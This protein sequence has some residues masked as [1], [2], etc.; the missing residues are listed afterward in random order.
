MSRTGERRDA[1]GHGLYCEIDGSPVSLLAEDLTTAGFFV[2][3]T[4][5]KA[6][7]REVEIF[8]RSPVGELHALGQ[9]VQ[10]VD[11]RRAKAEKRRTGYG[12]LFTTLEDDQRAFI[13]LTLDALERKQRAKAQAAAKSVPVPVAATVPPPSP[14]SAHEIKQIAADLR[15]ELTKLQGKTAWT[16]LGLEPDA[17]LASAKES[18]LRTSKRFH[19][20]KFARHNSAE[21]TKLATE[22]F[23]AYKRSYSVLTKLAPRGSTPTQ[24]VSRHQRS[25]MSSIAPAAAAA[26]I[27]PEANKTT[28]NRPRSR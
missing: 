25:T 16:A 20:H 9:V 13:G 18:F 11:E 4:T 26:S 5:P 21:I 15:A 17:S 1:E 14:T 10:V 19:P 28:G 12:V 3:T 24:D 27:R 2:Q 22:V 23:I 8:V 7:D 6:M